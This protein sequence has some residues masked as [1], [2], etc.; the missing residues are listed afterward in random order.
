MKK[1]L[2]MLLLSVMLCV[3]LTGCGMIV[4]RPEIKEGEFNISVT[5]EFNGEVKT[6]EGVYVCE[7]NGTSWALDGGSRRDWS[8]YIKDGK[9]ED[10]IDLGI[11]AEGYRVELNL[12][13]FPEHF[14]GESVEGYEYVATPY[15]TVTVSNDEGIAVLHGKDSEGYCNA[16]IIGYKY[17]E[18]IENSFSLFN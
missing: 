18:P 4:T 11:T 9:F 10:V 8:G 14:M 3:V 7:Y 6:L 2:S 16:R 13:L 12:A 15:I 17:D 1:I 5:Y